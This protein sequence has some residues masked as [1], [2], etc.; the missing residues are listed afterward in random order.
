[1]NEFEQLPLKSRGEEKN[2]L[3]IPQEIYDHILNELRIENKTD[4][5]K[6]QLTDIITYLRKYKHGGNQYYDRA[7]EIICHLD[8]TRQPPQM[9]IDVAFILEQ[10]YKTITTPF[11]ELGS[12]RQNILS[13]PSPN[14][15]KKMPL[16]GQDLYK[17][18]PTLTSYNDIEQLCK[19]RLD[20]AVVNKLWNMIFKI[21]T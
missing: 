11:A 16:I 17:F 12:S 9:P 8:P 10:L 2:I 18:P 6:L 3:Q 13:Y 5:T 15:S 20:D 14:Q 7:F 1:M 21:D 4:L 19:N